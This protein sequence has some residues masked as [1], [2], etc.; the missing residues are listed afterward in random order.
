M[1]GELPF[2]DAL[3]AGDVVFP[4]RLKG[5]Y[6]DEMIWR[7]LC[8][9]LAQHPA[10]VVGPL[11]D[12]PE[13]GLFK[14][15]GLPFR[16]PGMPDVP[17]EATAV[18]L[19][20]G[21][22]MNDIWDLGIRVLSHVLERAPREARVIVGP[23]SYLFERVDLAGLLRR[24]PSREIVLFARERYSYE[25]VLALGLPPNV[26][27]HLD[28][29]L[30]FQLEGALPSFP[31]RGYTLVCFREDVESA[32]AQPPPLKGVDVL[33]LDVSLHARSYEEFLETICSAHAVH[34]DRLHV[35]LAAVMAGRELVLY[36]NSYHKVRGV[37]EYSLVGRPG[38]RFAG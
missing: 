23:Q 3:A 30:A 13:F 22:N 25:H 14:V 32:G 36:P 7:G 20:G 21:G 6:G 15:R 33:S 35:A 4:V 2:T 16:R 19:S 31:D 17:R 5:N 34:T 18:V 38:V 10:R 27:V 28:H 29:D 37:Y 9:L 12:S 24:H 8:R 1:E 26:R 11:E